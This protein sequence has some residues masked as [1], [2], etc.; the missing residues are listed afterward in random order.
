MYSTKESATE[1]LNTMHESIIDSQKIKVRWSLTKDR[2]TRGRGRGRER[3]RGMGRG[4]GRGGIISRFATGY[5]RALP[6][7]K[8]QEKQELKAKEER[9]SLWYS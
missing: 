9:Q 4:R 2:R 7:N 3:E 5:G 6:Q 1:A 8:E